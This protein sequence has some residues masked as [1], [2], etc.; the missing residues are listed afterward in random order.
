MGSPPPNTAPDPKAQMVS[1]IGTMA[2]MGVVFYFLAIRPQQKRAKEHV[3]LLKGIRP[4]D[5][6]VTSSG[7][8]GIVLTVKEK[9]VTIRSIDAKL[10]LT[11]AAITEITER[12]SDTKES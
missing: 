7:I 3:N 10:E 2:L 6:V 4:G 9:T 11:K 12:S 1:M 5:K 8:V